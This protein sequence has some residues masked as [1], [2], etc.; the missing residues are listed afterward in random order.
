MDNV[1]VVGA[2]ARLRSRS[3]RAAKR[4]SA[5]ILAI[6][7]SLSFIKS[8]SFFLR[9]LRFS[10][11]FLSS[12]IS[13]SHSLPPPPPSF[14]GPSSSDESGV[15]SIF[16]GFGSC[17]WSSPFSSDTGL[18]SFLSLLSSSES[19]ERRDPDLFLFLGESCSFPSL[20]LPS[21]SLPLPNASLT[22]L[23]LVLTTSSF[24]SFLSPLRDLD[25]LLDL[26]APEAL[27]LSLR[28]DLDLDLDRG[29][30]IECDFDLERDLETD[31]ET[32]RDLERDLDLD[33]CDPLDNT[34]CDLDLDTTDRDLD[35][36]LDDS[37]LLGDLDRDLELFL[38]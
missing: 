18:S 31:L 17:G 24:S 34:D 19:E 14:L 15:F 27:D 38:T 28:T 4:I 8:I 33:F 25:L 36:A 9:R 2:L 26:E 5:I 23:F 1:L 7:S 6:A 13:K 35:L 20:S 32:E 16:S 21:E 10:A 3:S 12:I 11:F 30:E 37:L 29:F 22:T